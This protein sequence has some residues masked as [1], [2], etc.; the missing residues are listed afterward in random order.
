MIKKLLFLP[1]LPAFFSLY[2]QTI[3]TDVLVIGNGPAAVAAAVQSARS[4]VKTVLAADKIRL[5]LMGDK[6]IVDLSPETPS[7]L[8]CDFV[9]SVKKESRAA[10]ADTLLT[11]RI[12]FSEQAGE[13]ALLK[14]TDSIKNLTVEPDMAFTGIEKSGDEWLL[15]FSRLGKT[16]EIK[17]KIVIDATTDG[18]VASKSG[19]EVNNI[20]LRQVG[21]LD[22]CRT[23]V[24]SGIVPTEPTDRTF[25]PGWAISL[26]AFL[27]SGVENLL[28]IGESTPEIADF[29]PVQFKLGQAAGAIAAYCSFFKTNTAHLK[30]RVIQGELLDFKTSLLPYSDISPADPD[31]RAIQQVGLTGLFTGNVPDL[32]FRPDSKV[33]TDEIERILIEIYSRAFLWFNKEKPGEYFTIANMLSFISDYTLTEPTILNAS[34]RKAWKTQFKFTTDFEPGRAITR[35]EFAVLANKYLNPFARTVDLDGKL[36][37]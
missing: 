29:L 22:L 6:H 25:Y 30:V 14:M 35:R 9:K 7:G 13:N 20:F 3:K 8:W 5:D 21:T 1:L 19:T 24:A 18:A 12:E 31:W 11:S 23:T 16:L 4:K 37:N 2:A 10:G 27:A 28:F 33:K 32:H 26:K 15:K 17:A 36:V 34:I